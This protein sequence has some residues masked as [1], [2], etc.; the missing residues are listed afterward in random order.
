MNYFSD[1]RYVDPFGRYLRLKSKVV[2]NRAAFCSFCPPKSITD[3]KALKDEITRES[4]DSV[5]MYDS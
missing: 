5:A 3:Q 2:R 4:S 1:F